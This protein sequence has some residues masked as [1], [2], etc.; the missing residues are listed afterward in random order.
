[1]G[2]LFPPHDAQSTCHSPQN[3]LLSEILASSSVSFPPMK[4]QKIPWENQKSK[5]ERWLEY[6]VPSEVSVEAR[7]KEMSVI[8]AR[9]EERLCS[10]TEKGRGEK[11]REIQRWRHACARQRRGTGAKARQPPSLLS[12]LAFGEE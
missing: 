6:R 8:G 3:P 11:E 7:A 2:F 9:G 4:I 10:A 5:S 12:P 1:M